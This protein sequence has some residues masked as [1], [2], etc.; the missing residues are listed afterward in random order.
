MHNP[1]FGQ[2]NE[3]YKV[4]K[5]FELQSDNLISSR[6]PDQMIINEKENLP[7]RGLC[8]PGRPQNEDE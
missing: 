8:C 2:E 1:E 7:N 3:I 6:R 4:L 5:D